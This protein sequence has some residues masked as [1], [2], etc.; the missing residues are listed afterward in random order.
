[1]GSMTSQ[2]T[3]SPLVRTVQPPYQSHPMGYPPKNLPDIVDNLEQKGNL[4]IRDFWQRWTESIHN[5]RVVNTGA[6]SYQ[7]KS[8]EKC[9]QKAENDKKKKYMYSCLQKRRHF[10]PFVV[11]LDGILGVEAE[12]ML[13]H[14]TSRLT[15]KW[16]KP[17][18]WTCG[19]V[20]STVEI[21]LVRAMHC[22]LQGSQVPMH[23]IIQIPQWG[24]GAIVHLFF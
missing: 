19:Q 13:K 4:R 1:M 16:N 3:I 18:P 12:A 7:N 14:I 22:C 21:T 6:L 11:S 24:D 9:L 20:K 5:M 8:K 2:A 23:I 15:K 10:Y 17:Y